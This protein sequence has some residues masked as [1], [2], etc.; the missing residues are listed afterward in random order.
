MAFLYTLCS[1]VYTISSVHENI[2]ENRNKLD[3]CIIRKRWPIVFLYI[4]LRVSIL[5]IFNVR[6]YNFDLI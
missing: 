4:L 6:C 1:F 5:Y 2:H 3:S